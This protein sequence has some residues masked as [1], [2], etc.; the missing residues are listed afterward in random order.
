M[1]M[2]MTVAEL[3][4]LLNDEWPSLTFGE[5]TREPDTLIAGQERVQ[6]LADNDIIELEITGH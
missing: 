4:T 1:K 3:R 6:T 2:V 5:I